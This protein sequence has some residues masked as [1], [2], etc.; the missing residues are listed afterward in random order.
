MAIEAKK[1]A[2]SDIIYFWLP[3]AL[4]CLIIISIYKIF[5]L[6]TDL[7]VTP[8]SALVTPDFSVYENSFRFNPLFAAMLQSA[9]TLPYPGASKL[10]F[11]FLAS[12]FA[13]L[14]I[15]KSAQK[16]FPLSKK[17]NN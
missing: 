8:K 9:N 12:G 11:S 14:S 10:I 16:I 13:Q 7:N 1:S 5:H 15:Q 2:K 17:G 3:R 4:S 6:S